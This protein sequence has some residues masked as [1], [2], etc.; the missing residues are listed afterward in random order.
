MQCSWTK[1]NAVCGPEELLDVDE[2]GE[3]KAEEAVCWVVRRGRNESKVMMT[4]LPSGLPALIVHTTHH[5]GIASFNNVFPRTHKFSVL[6][7]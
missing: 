4:K 3:A 6:H 2:L 5:H 1:L 7:Y